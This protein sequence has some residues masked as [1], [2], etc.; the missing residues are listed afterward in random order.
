MPDRLRGRGREARQG[1]PPLWRKWLQDRFAE[2][3]SSRPSSA[4]IVVGR[5]HERSR[6]SKVRS[7]EQTSG[8][9]LDG[10][11]LDWGAA[12]RPWTASVNERCLSI[13]KTFEDTL[14]DSGGSRSGYSMRFSVIE[15]RWNWTAASFVASTVDGKSARRGSGG[16]SP[17]EPS[18][19]RRGGDG[20]RQ[21]GRSPSPRPV[22]RRGTYAVVVTVGLERPAED[23]DPTGWR[24]RTRV[25]PCPRSCSSRFSSTSRFVS[26]WRS[27]LRTMLRTMQGDE[28]GGISAR[29]RGPSTGHDEL[30]A[31]AGGPQTKCSTSWNGSNQSTA[32][33]DRGRPPATCPFANVQLAARSG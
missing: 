15:S 12:S 28:R 11:P 25:R 1:T 10:P 23:A 20:S 33:A 2:H 24:V 4:I 29:R 26:F 18:R 17:G 19:P 32:G 22:A 6:T 30:A 21:R 13:P 16:S 5:G 9:R 3:E 7:F 14:H 27:L 8:R 31:I